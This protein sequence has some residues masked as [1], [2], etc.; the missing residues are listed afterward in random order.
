MPESRRP[1][2][3]VHTNSV[4]LDAGGDFIVSAAPDQR[5]LPDLARERPDRSGGSA[6]SARTSSSGRATRFGLQH[7]ARP[8]PDGSLTVFDNSAPP[9]QRK[10]SRAITL[11]LDRG[12]RRRRCVRALKHPRACCRRPRAAR[13]GSP[14]AACSSAG[15]RTAASPSTT[16]TGAW[17]STATSGSAATTTAPTGSRGAGGRHGPP[18][19]VATRRGRS[20]RPRVSWNGAT[21]VATWK[22]WAGPRADA[23]NRVKG[24]AP[25]AGSRRRSRRSPP[26]ASF[27]PGRSTSAAQCWVQ[28]NDPDRFVRALT[29]E[30]LRPYS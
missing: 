30:S 9:P 19:L 16:P 6:A 2:D 14:R 3:Y 8:Q 23:L 10:A 29:P 22:L 28:R 25:H 15:A 4:A 27:R 24:A 7:D 17:C 1:W 13:S 12:A 21:D 5:G 20:G 26:D 18:E 11:G